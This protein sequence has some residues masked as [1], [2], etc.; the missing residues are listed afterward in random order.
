[1]FCEE[2]FKAAFPG[3]KALDVMKQIVSGINTV[4]SSIGSGDTRRAQHS[5]RVVRT[6]LTAAA[7][8]L[9]CMPFSA[10]KAVAREANSLLCTI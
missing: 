7:Q 5:V 6:Q 9:E 1:M 3:K 2:R 10:D 4:R 8:L